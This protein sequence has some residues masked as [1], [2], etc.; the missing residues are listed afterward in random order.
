MKKI[1]IMLMLTASLQAQ[2]NGKFAKVDATQGYTVNGAAPNNQVLC[3]NG[4]T[5][6]FTA[7]CGTVSV[8]F[9]QTITLASTALPQRFFTDYNATYFAV[10]DEGPGAGTLIELHSTL[11]ISVTGNAATATTAAALSGT[12]TQC[13]GSAPLATGIA[14]NGN[15]NCTAAPASVG[16]AVCVSTGCYRIATDGVTEEWGTVSVPPSGTGTNNATISFPHTF[17]STSNLAVTFSTVGIAG[18]GDP[19]DPPGA[20]LSSLST[21]SASVFMARFIQASEGGGTFNN[22]ITLTWHAIGF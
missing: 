11:P 6:V 21:S 8:P 17:T 13:S 9:Y 4:T 12:P 7:S 22:T 16:T 10:T 19:N 1:L 18:S 5:A 3:G 20:Q 14:A 2:V 15:A